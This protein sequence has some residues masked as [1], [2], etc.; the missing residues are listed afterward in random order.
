MAEVVSTL[1]RERAV[2]CEKIFYPIKSQLH[3]FNIIGFAL[4]NTFIGYIK[5]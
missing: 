5:S 4:P 1:R 2:A 3:H